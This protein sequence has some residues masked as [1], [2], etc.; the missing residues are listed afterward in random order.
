[1]GTC[2]HLFLFAHITGLIFPPNVV[3]F[4]PSLAVTNLTWIH[5]TLQKCRVSYLL[6]SFR[7]IQHQAK[8]SVFLK[9]VICQSTNLK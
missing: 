3:S 8:S 6:L 9:H 2:K 5:S 7:F 1:M 4:A